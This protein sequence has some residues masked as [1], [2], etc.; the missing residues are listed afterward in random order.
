MVHPLVAV[1]PKYEFIWTRRT[2]A[3]LQPQR[4]RVL[5]VVNVQ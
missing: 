3:H 5:V 2:H 4:V 1:E